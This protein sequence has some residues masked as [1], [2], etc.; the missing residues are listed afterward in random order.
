MVL[1]VLGLVLFLGLHS[2]RI[3]GD[4]PREA[5]LSRL[6]EGPYKGL[7]S[8]L[9]LAG[10]VLIGQGY[11]AALAGSSMAWIPPT[12]LRHV[13]LLLVPLAFILVAS[14]YAPA[15]H[16]KRLARHPMVLGVALW[17]LGHL[18]ANGETA[19]VIL[20]GAFLAWAAADY[21]ASLRRAPQPVRGPV[22]LKG[23][24]AAVL[25]GGGLALAFILGLHQWLIGVSPIN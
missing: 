1:L 24:V 8:L 4:A 5:L 21:A 10:L 16:I 3:A 14:A 9:S 2:L 19:N 13:T 12:G 7:Y 23:D 25:V 22:T 17:S 18:L 6:G 11:G 15:G 20:F